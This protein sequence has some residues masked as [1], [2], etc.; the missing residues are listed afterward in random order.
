MARAERAASFIQQFMP[1]TAP[2]S[3][4]L[5][6]AYDLAAYINSHP[7]P[8]SPNKENDWPKGGAPYDVPYATQG[9]EAFHPPELIT[10][11]SPE[12]AVVP[13]PVSVRAK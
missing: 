9:H 6:E 12:T 13:A 10:R 2:G 4:S 11:K 8:D 7:R 1:Q 3:L 5:Q